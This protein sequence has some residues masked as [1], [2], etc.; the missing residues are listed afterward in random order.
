MRISAS[1]D[2]AVTHEHEDAYGFEWVETALKLVSGEPTLGSRPPWNLLAAANRRRVLRPSDP[3][4]TLSDQSSG[5]GFVDLGGQ[6]LRVTRKFPPQYPLNCL[7]KLLPR[8]RR[9]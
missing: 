1:I 7:S 2:D 9:L 5:M 3:Q 8:Q 6:P 4:R